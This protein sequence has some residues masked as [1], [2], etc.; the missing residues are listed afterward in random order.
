MEI[1]FIVFIKVKQRE[2]KMW[3]INP[4]RK[5]AIHMISRILL[6]FCLTQTG[7]SADFWEPTAGPAGAHVYSMAAVHG[8]DICIGTDSGLYLTSDGGDNWREYS[9]G[10]T[11][12]AVYALAV[13]DGGRLYA[14]TRG[15]LFKRDS[16]DTAW[17]NISDGMGY[18]WVKAIAADRDGR[19]FAGVADSS[20]GT[21]GSL[22]LSEDAGGN[23]TEV[24][25]GLIG[26]DVT[27]ALSAD[28]SGSVFT[29]TNGGG[30]LQRDVLYEWDDTVQGWE[31]IYWFAPTFSVRTL[32]VNPANIFFAGTDIGVMRSYNRGETWEAA[33]LFRRMIF[34]VVFRDDTTLFVATGHN[35][36][37]YSDNNGTKWL[38]RSSGL[39]PNRAILSLAKD[40]DGRLF[41]GTDGRGVY[42]SVNPA[43]GLPHA[44][45]SNLPGGIQLLQNYPN[46]FNP[47]TVIPFRLAAAA[48]VRLEIL[49]LLGQRVAVLWDRH[50]PAGEYEIPF[51]AGELPGGIY[52]YR[53]D[54][55]QFRQT[56]KLILQK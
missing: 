19:L 10:L 1:I 35:G 54:A 32:A 6:V 27:R 12:S 51:A 21:V 9:R 15:G 8:S 56:R 5:A 26:Q 11:N 3:K 18:R 50:L 49:N 52:Y 45:R 17:V 31:Q 16:S 47:A 37:Y 34:S 48:A 55:G 22:Y 43:L 13:N 39:P 41:A 20:T 40:A 44:G 36:I 46:P 29:V 53:L 7:R 14:G 23:W 25:S 4:S 28:S 24:R 30:I 42:R 38:N 2:K 33:G